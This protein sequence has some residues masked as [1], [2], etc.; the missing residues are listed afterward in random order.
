[1]ESENRPLN[2]SGLK[3]SGPTTMES[4]NESTNVSVS[5]SAEILTKD[6]HDGETIETPN[7]LNNVSM[8]NQSV[9]KSVKSITHDQEHKVT[10]TMT[11]DDNEKEQ[12]EEI[13]V[14][15]SNL[16]NRSALESGAKSISRDFVPEENIVEIEFPVHPE[17]SPKGSSRKRS[18]S[19]L[20]N[21]LV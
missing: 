10:E 4:I 3:S 13:V 16:S 2:K 9:S 8:S 1:M 11:Q 15:Q 14:D 6:N 18:A 20:K 5:K 7:S 21:R 19:R 12:V 17:G